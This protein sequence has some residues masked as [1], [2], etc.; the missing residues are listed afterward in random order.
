MAAGG[1]L[2]A[3]TSA[4]CEV[5]VRAPAP[6]A[7]AA[8]AH[9][10]IP[11]TEAPLLAGGVG[12]RTGWGFVID[13]EGRMVTLHEV[14]PVVPSASGVTEILAE[15][16][17]TW[18]ATIAAGVVWTDGSQWR[19]HALHTGRLRDDHVF[20]VA[21]DPN[22][23]IWVATQEGITRIAG[24]THTH[25]PVEATPDR[26]IRAVA[27]TGETV[28][29]GTHGGAV[30]RLDRASG[31]W[32]TV[33][34]SGAP[35]TAL[36]ADDGGAWVGT[37]GDGVL[38]LAPDGTVIRR[39]SRPRDVAALATEPGLGAWAGAAD[40]SVLHL[41]EVP[42][43]R[44]EIVPASGPDPADLAVSLDADVVS[45]PPGAFLMGSDDRLP[46]EA[47]QRTVS[48]SG[49][50]IHRHEV[51]NVQYDRY[52]R[53]TGAPP[54]AAWPGGAVPPGESLHPVVGVRA[55]E[56]AAYCEWLAMRL[57][58]EAEWERAAR[59]GD[60]RAWPWGA[61]WDPDLANTADGGP[62][63]TTPVG[64]Y[65]SGASPTGVLDVAGNAAEWVSDYYDADSYRTAPDTDPSGPGAVTNRVRRGG[66]WAS[67]ADE[68]RTARRTSS[69]GAAPDLRAG[70]RCVRSG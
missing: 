59:G 65:P 28:W 43:A 19:L 58:T 21:A 16:D 61:A 47:P 20:D 55:E 67:P 10:T 66:S 54:P 39:D 13:R 15:P 41:R 64:S 5:A 62:G 14:V 48:L 42:A 49:F 31:T 30:A 33:L 68:A 4:G 34:A 51:T 3:C 69:H 23:G 8:V 6:L 29:A 52:V 53:A 63:W 26:R 7:L 27:A 9:G 60:G 17:G 70:F 46:D 44:Y 36:A 56:A 24:D 1:R 40:G 35:V 32:Q 12:P 45:I 57:P 11:A 37:A 2:S 22:G 50:R 25:V 38:H 18:I